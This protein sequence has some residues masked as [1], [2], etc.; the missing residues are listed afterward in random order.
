MSLKIICA[1]ILLLIWAPLYPYDKLPQYIGRSYLISVDGKVIW[2]FNHR[3]KLPPASLTKLMTALII[4]EKESIDEIVE[5]KKDYNPIK[6]SK[7]GILKGEKYSVNDLL[8]AMLMQSANDACVLLAEYVAR[9]E[10]HFV[11]LMNERGKELRLKNTRFKNPCGHDQEGHYSSAEDLYILTQYLWRNKKFK[12]IVSTKEIVISPLNRPDRKLSLKN[13]NE[14]LFSYDGVA[15]VKTGNTLKAGECLILCLEKAGRSVM[16]VML[17]TPKRFEKAKE[18][19][20][21][22]LKYH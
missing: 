8:H 3:L 6:G 17:N 21:L 14:L 10:T 4:L 7:I 13:S 19:L 18:I 15:G 5:V 12:E 1:F 9:S 22:V 20:D 16:I 11:K 2:A